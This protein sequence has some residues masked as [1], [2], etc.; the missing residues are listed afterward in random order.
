MTRG[1]LHTCR[2]RESI[3]TSSWWML[4]CQLKLLSVSCETVQ[5]T[6]PDQRPGFLLVKLSFSCTTDN[7]YEPAWKHHST[8]GWPTE[9]VAPTRKNETSQL[10]HW[11]PGTTTGAAATKTT[12]TTKKY[13]YLYH[14]YYCHYKT[15]LF[16]LLERPTLQRIRLVSQ[17]DV[18]A[19]RHVEEAQETHHVSLESYGSPD[20]GASSWSH[21][22]GLPIWRSLKWFQTTR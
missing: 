22:T 16:L 21:G 14:S 9:M 1:F 12:A 4:H 6:G 10:A 15:P 7:Q 18:I 20:G 19:I 2:I 5:P 13:H 11:F 8:G 3:A 17:K